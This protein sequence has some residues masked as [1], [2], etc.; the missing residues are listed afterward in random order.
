MVGFLLLRDFK[1]SKF[2][3]I[4]TFQWWSVL[5]GYKISLTVSFIPLRDLKDG[6]FCSIMR[7]KWQSVLFLNEISTMVVVVFSVMRFQRRSDFYF[8]NEI[9]V[10][11]DFVPLFLYKI[12]KTVGFL[13]LQNFTDGWFYSFT[14]SQSQWRFCFVMRFQWWLVLF[15]YGISVGLLYFFV[16]LRDFKDSLFFLKFYYEISM[17]G[18]FVLL[19]DLNECQV[20]LITTFQW[21]SVLFSYEISMTDGLVSLRD[22]SYSRFCSITRFKWWSVLFLYGI[23]M[24]V[25]FHCQSVKFSFVQLRDLNMFCSFTRF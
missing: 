13:F 14:R 6:P 3:S 4:T 19:R 23:S 7:F 20:C 12:S 18:D 21:W 16:L 2:C 25:S 11:V 22:S 1:D 9:S 24:T 8:I 5:F 15:G 17:M 10:T